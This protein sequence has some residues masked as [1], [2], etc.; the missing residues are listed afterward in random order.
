MEKENKRNLI[1]K[2]IVPKGLKSE[3]NKIKEYF[4]HIIEVYGSVKIWNNYDNICV[5]IFEEGK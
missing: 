5:E 1:I 2:M 4:D 3:F